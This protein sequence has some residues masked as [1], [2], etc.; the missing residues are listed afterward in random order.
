MKGF[1]EKLIQDLRYGIRTILKQPG[2][3]AIA[4]MALA[5]GI[6]ANTAIF[7][8]VNAVLLRP[9]PFAN[10]NGIMMVYNT[11]EKEDS[12]SVT[13]PDFI[14][15]R[16]NQQSFQQLAAYSTR[17]FTLTGTGDPVRLR[18]AMV[19]SELFPILGVQPKLGRFFRPEEDK[20]DVRVA[21]L[22]HRMWQ[23]HFA[24][25]PGICEKTIQL[26]G[27]SFNVAG[28]MPKG[29]AFPVQNDPVID[30]WTTT[31]ILQE[32]AAPLTVQRGNHALNV[33]ARLK[34]GVTIE[35]AQSDMSG[36]VNAL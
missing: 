25:D 9:L 17:D 32:G 1:M 18:G 20:P 21:I 31:S 35:Q 6:G 34:E 24:S 19:T 7:S 22:S 29:F 11:A 14:D 4:V 30:F 16:E 33:I 5:L 13:Y 27:Q 23:E 8:V 10:P 36:I 3:T 28:V 15:W 26:H 12:F 2:F